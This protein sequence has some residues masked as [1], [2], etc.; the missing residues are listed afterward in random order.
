MRQH[1][2]ATPDPEFTTRF[3]RECYRFWWSAISCRESYK[4][5]G[6]DSSVLCENDV[7]SVTS[8]S[9][10]YQSKAFAQQCFRECVC[11]RGQRPLISL[12]GLN[13]HKAAKA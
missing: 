12:I 11:I 1:R 4:L 7:S 8:G 2:Q 5:D 13:G 10:Y 6:V 9:S 3:L